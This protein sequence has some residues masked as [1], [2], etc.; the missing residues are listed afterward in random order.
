MEK[1]EITIDGKEYVLK[2][3][4]KTSEK[5]KS[6][7]GMEYCIIRTYSAGVFAGYIDRK[8][9]GASRTI[10]KARRLWYWKTT[11]LDVSTIA[12]KGVVVD[13]CR[14]SEIRDEI[15]LENVIEVQPCNKIAQETIEKVKVYENA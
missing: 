5:A 14:F 10:F 6:M 15:D 11:G 9:K 1:N 12:E 8:I 4:I 3:S 2:S 7:K 13:K